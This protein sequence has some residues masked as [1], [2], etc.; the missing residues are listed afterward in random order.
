MSLFLYFFCVAGGS[1]FLMKTLLSHYVGAED[2]QVAQSEGFLFNQL[3]Y[4]DIELREIK[5]LPQDAVLKIQQLDFALQWPDVERTSLTL[6]NGRIIFPLEEPLLFYG[7]YQNEKLDVTVYTREINVKDLLNLFTGG[8]SFKRVSGNVVNLESYL[9][10]PLS[11]VALTGSFQLESFS[12]NRFLLTESPGALNFKRVGLPPQVQLEGEILLEKGK[13]FLTPQALI[14]LKPSRIIFSGDPKTP[15]L[16][17]KG[18]ATVEGT[19]IHLKLAGDL[20][21][22]EL[23][24][25]SQP[26]MPQERLLIM[27]ATGKSWRHAAAALEQGHISPESAG[28]FIDYFLHAG[29]AN[30][31]TKQLGIHVEAVTLTDQAK[32]IQIKKAVTDRLETRYGIEQAQED[33]QQRSTTHKA[34][35]GIK[36]TDTLS[37][38]GERKMK[39]LDTSHENPDVP[40]EDEV[41]LKYKKTF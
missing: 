14:E 6:R 26:P 2:I 10:G 38:E 29:P 25:T 30:R 4:K 24:L 32:G 22:P 19:Q 31:F 23:Q 13:V 18:S 27:L 9:Q 16:D 11:N 20:D 41:L 21:Q 17:I 37:L 15:T 1:T 28:E 33:V 40:P 39:Q 36:V 7:A 3:S 35:V 34:G 5:G 8:E 12:N